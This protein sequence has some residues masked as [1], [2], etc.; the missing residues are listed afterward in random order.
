M[1]CSINVGGRNYGL[2]EATLWE[3]R[4]TVFY[5]VINYTS[6]VSDIQQFQVLT[7]KLVTPHFVATNA[8]NWT[9][10]IFN[11]IRTT[12]KLFKTHL[13]AW[14]DASTINTGTSSVHDKF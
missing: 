12:E 4:T 2:Q 10:V 14:D 3:I 11:I 6:S 7:L 13:H 8:K 9:I 1:R 5:G